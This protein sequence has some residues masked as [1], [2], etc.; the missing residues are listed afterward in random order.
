MAFGAFGSFFGRPRFLGVSSAIDYDFILWWKQNYTVHRTH[1]VIDLIWS[2]RS[3]T[4]EKRLS[5]L[6]TQII[7]SFGGGVVYCRY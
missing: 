5:S 7:T 4:V 1:I 6:E 2:L 3:Y